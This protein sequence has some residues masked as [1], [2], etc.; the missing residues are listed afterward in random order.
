MA[1]VERLRRGRPLLVCEVM[2]A[3]D[4][5]TSLAMMRA[6]FVDDCRWRSYRYVNQDG[7]AAIGR[8]RRS[9]P[10]GAATGHPTA[11]REVDWLHVSRPSQIPA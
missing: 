7:A 9:V 8:A 1:Q 11:P 5:P 2:T 10:G 3:L 4:S 6:R